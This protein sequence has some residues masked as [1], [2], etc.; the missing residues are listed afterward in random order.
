M[1]F[2]DLLP[3]SEEVR[4]LLGE[5][6][7]SVIVFEAFEKHLDFLSGLDLARLLELVQGDRAFALEPELQDDH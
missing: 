6:D 3:D 1:R 7:D 2:L 4:L 5:D